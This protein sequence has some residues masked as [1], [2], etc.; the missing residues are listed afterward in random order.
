MSEIQCVSEARHI[1]GEG[2]LWCAG[3][4]R[5]YW[6][7]IQG[8]RL[9]WLEP[10]GAEGGFD[11]PIR[12]S[13]ACVRSGGGLLLATEAGLARFDT[14]SGDLEMA[15]PAD[16]GPGFRTNDGK[17]DVA[18]RFWWSSMDDNGG[19]R[20]GVVYRTDPDGRT[21]PVL[22]AIH[23]P[24]TLSC[25]PAG[26]VLYLADSRKQVLNA[27]PMDK[28]GELGPPRPFIDLTGEDGAPDGSAVDEAGF[29]WN[30]QWGAWRLVRYAPDGRLDRI[31]PLPVAQ[32]TSCAFGGPD[33][34][35][36]YVTSAREGLSPAALAGQPLAGG[37]FAFRPGVKGLSLPLFEG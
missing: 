35:T 28:Q 14:G 11:L 33:L 24:N 5:L 31:V 2:P 26:D 30:A 3:E 20:P 10:G 23:I 13:A 8:R 1:L 17:I 18:G 19:E 37:L 9:A 27:Y 34:A 16:L 29:V 7:D 21:T 22:A 36:L 15:E 4:G 12:A 25:N 32:P 6:F